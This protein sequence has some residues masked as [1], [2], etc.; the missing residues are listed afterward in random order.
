[1]NTNEKTINELYDAVL[2][3]AFE[4]SNVLGAGFLEKVYELAL[5]RELALSGLRCRAQAALR[6]HYKGTRV[7]NYFADLLVEDKLIV[8]L[9]CVERLAPEHLAK[10]LNYLRATDLRIALLVNFERPR[11]EYKRVLNGF[12]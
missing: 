7:G 2:R 12:D 11:L 9:K 8:E 1:M 4:V 3:V 5:I 10:C 6:I